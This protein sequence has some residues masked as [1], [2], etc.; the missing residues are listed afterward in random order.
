MH[1]LCVVCRHK[2][3]K[4]NIVYFINKILTVTLQLSVFIH[5]KV[6]EFFKRV[7]LDDLKQRYR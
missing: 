1:Y 7:M 3:E 5:Y 2:A 4:L 6:L